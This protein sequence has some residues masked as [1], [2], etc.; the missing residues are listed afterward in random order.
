MRSLLQAVAIVV[1]AATVVRADA[2]LYATAATTNGV[3]GFCVR[4]DGS[5]APTPNTHV[6]TRGKNPRRLVVGGNTL[7]VAETDRVEVFRI[8]PH[9]GLKSV[10]S[11]R[12]LLTPNKMNPLDVALSPDLKMLYVPQSGQRRIAAYPLG[13]DGKFTLTKDSDPFAGDFSSCIQAPVGPRYRRI[14]VRDSLLYVTEAANNGAVAIYPLTADPATGRLE[15][16]LKPTDCVLGKTPSETTCPL[17]ERRR[18]FAPNAFILDGDRI[19]VESLFHHRIFAFPLTNGLFDP[20]F[21]Q[22][23]KAPKD[24]VPVCLMDSDG[25]TIKGPFRWAPSTSKTNAAEKYQD[26]VF[27]DGTLLASQFLQGRIDAF[28]LKSDGSL[29][30]RPTRTTTGDLRGSP[31]GLAVRG[32]V[33]YVAAGELDRVQAFHIGRTNALPEPTPFSETDEQ[34]DSFPNALAVAE[35]SDSC[36]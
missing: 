17:S 1:L 19:Y 3:D 36:P 7:Y 11:T 33:L 15:L 21:P 29:P 25:N 6:G 30:R 35:L 28:Q 8:G 27:Q 12:P 16:Q 20:L 32:N 4:N 10:G 24:T 26:L 5:L 18:L 2:I 34:T 13:D 22:H 14:A 9:G 31:V 23:K